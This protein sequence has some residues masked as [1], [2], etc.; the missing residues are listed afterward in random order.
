M[1]NELEYAA[2]NKAFTLL[3][4]AT[5]S[6]NLPTR[7]QGLFCLLQANPP[8]ERLRPLVL[9]VL[10][11]RSLWPKDSMTPEGFSELNRAVPGEILGWESY[12]YSI[13]EA[14]SRAFGTKIDARSYDV[15]WSKADRTTLAQLLGG[16]D[17]FS[18]FGDSSAATRVWPPI[19][20]AETGN[21]EP[22]S[23][24]SDNEA[25]AGMASQVLRHWELAAS[26]A[27]AMLAALGVWL[28]VIRRRKGLGRGTD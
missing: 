21:L 2:K 9:S 7:S 24:K 8:Q 19:R 27:I 23:G 28:F 6:T 25:G 18:K 11:N 26:T 13:C 3:E 20:G 4:E 17:V 14:A 22:R 10:L 5:Y 12:Q 1:E 15:P 16:P